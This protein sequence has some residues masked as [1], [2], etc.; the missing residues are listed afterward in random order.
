MAKAISV[1]GQKYKLDGK[2]KSL[3]RKSPK[4]NARARA[5]GKCARG[6]SL[7]ER[8]KCFETVGG[9]KGK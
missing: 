5:I 6:K 8:K 7:P 1:F 4:P 2:V 3:F 9:V